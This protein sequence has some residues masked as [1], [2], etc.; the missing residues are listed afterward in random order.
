M[1]LL[2]YFTPSSSP[3]KTDILDPT[4]SSEELPANKRTRHHTMQGTQATTRPSTSVAGLAAAASSEQRQP[5]G[6]LG[7]E[8]RF[9]PSSGSNVA[10]LTTALPPGG[11]TPAE[12]KNDPHQPTSGGTKI[13]ETNVPIFHMCRKLQKLSIRAYNHQSNLSKLIENKCVPKGLS[14]CRFP[15]NIPNPSV[16]FQIRWDAAHMELS[17]KL[18]KL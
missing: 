12:S 3:K 11:T 10:I 15:L 17:T 6:G 13:S 18:T 8:D 4:S 1:S 9:A 2:A 16:S 7:N 14:V 5:S